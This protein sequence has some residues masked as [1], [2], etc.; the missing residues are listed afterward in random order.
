MLSTSHVSRGGGHVYVSLELYSGISV[1]CLA[2]CHCSARLASSLHKQRKRSHATQ[3]HKSNWLWVALH[4]GSIDSPFAD[5]LLECDNECGRTKRLD[6][7]S[8]HCSR[9]R[10]K[11]EWFRSH[12]SGWLFADYVDPVWSLLDYPFK[13]NKHRERTPENSLSI[14]LL[15]GYNIN[16]IHCTPNL[17]QC[18]KKLNFSSV[19]KS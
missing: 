13:N 12:C 5:L 19:L 6:Q 4:L 10:G 18:L 1:F 15:F 2:C 9:S 17:L 11:H 3:E 8:L 14:S 7:S 16:L